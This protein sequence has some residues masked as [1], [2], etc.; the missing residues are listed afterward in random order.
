MLKNYISIALRSLSRHKSFSILNI[1]GLS[2]GII[3]FMIILLYIQYE[4]SFN[5]HIEN[6]ENKYRV[7][8]IQ[9][10]P[11]VGE[12]HVAVTMLP[13]AEALQL[14]YPEIKSVL[15]IFR[16]YGLTAQHKNKSFNENWFAFADSTVFD[17]LS[18][19]LKIGD[20]R[21]ALQEIN[22]IVLSEK[23]AKKY[24]K[25]P[26]KAMDKMLTIMGEPFIITGII[27][28]YTEKSSV[29]FNAIGN[30]R[31]LEENWHLHSSWNSNSLDTYVELKDG[32]NKEELES[33]FPGF[34]EKYMAE[35]WENP[36]ELY[37]Q[38][39]KDI[40]LKSNHI[41]FQ[42]YNHR[43]GDIN[44]V[45]IFSIIAILVLVI[46][47]INYINLATSMATRR[48]K[49]VGVRKVLGAHKPKLVSQFLGE[50]FILCIVSGILALGGIAVL[51][52]EMNTILGIEMK[53][54]FNNPVFT[55][56]L[57]GTILL[58][59][60]FSGIYPALYMSGFKPTVIFSG[61]RSSRGKNNSG[62]LRKTLVVSQFAVSII[63]II[64]TIIAVS[65]VRY[66]HT[67]DKGYNDKA[68]YSIPLRFPDEE[69]E[70]NMDLL[71]SELKNNAD[72][73]G[74]SS[75]SSPTGVSGGQ[76]GI[77]VADTAE[78]KLMVRFGYFDPLYLPLMDIDIVKGRNFSKDRPTDI[79]HSIIL[80]EIAVEKLG[81][82]NPI[83]KQFQPRGEDSVNTT[84]IG[85]IKDYNYYSLRSPIEPAAYYYDPGRFENVNIK[86]NNA[87]LG[88]SVDKIK[89]TWNKLF[90]STPFGGFFMD[91]RY[92]AQY[93]NEINTTKIFG[94]FAMLCIF[95]SCLGLFGLVSF[96]VNQK[97]KEIAIRKVFGS[98]VKQVVAVISKEFIMLVIVAS[99]IGIPVAYYYMGKW[100]NNFAYKVSLSWYYFVL[101]VLAATVIAFSTIIYKAVSAANANPAN[102]LRDE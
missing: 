32:A 91:D 10:E 71:I 81:W 100:L 79:R 23:I 64:A 99:S 85:V 68:V 67:K 33:K 97:T 30:F 82:K 17:M 19:K 37:I 60:L 24:F 14:E 22:S 84:V 15:R 11:G 83:G 1:L 52:P 80:N 94:I 50:S 44:Q 40:H 3:S 54:H 98:N 58:V 78:T 75:T 96:V 31:M 46:A 42:T 86:L 101:A 90:P 87:N 92:Q 28:D 95:I 8:E 7:V 62:L 41:K 18:V 36:P 57:L 102:S 61:F 25:T 73:K 53:M 5:A 6:L 47:C 21:T 70:R 77:F 34:V 12:Q 59:G 20:K 4:M 76:G 35:V 16:A 51:L 88:E 43:Q 49:E 74:I 13:L 63:I 45:Y 72:V 39:V 38:P 9:T 48:A 69:K 27:A 26:E 56:G 55:G 93:A 66:F 29:Y 89:T 65:Q 2:I